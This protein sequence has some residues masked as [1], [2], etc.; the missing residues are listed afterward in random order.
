MD[1]YSCYT[2]WLGTTRNYWRA[3]TPLQIAFAFVFSNIMQAIEHY[4]L[5]SYAMTATF[6]PPITVKFHLTIMAALLSLFSRVGGTIFSLGFGVSLPCLFLLISKEISGLQ[7]MKILQKKKSIQH[8]V[9][10]CEI[11]MTI[12]SPTALFIFFLSSK[13]VFKKT[14]QAALY[15]LTQR[16]SLTSRY[17]WKKVHDSKLQKIFLL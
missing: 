5:M 6:L 4:N 10:F 12:L 16:K 3:K 9:R 13:A 11:Q 1:T 7:N 8:F 17:S 14:F 15:R 2:Y